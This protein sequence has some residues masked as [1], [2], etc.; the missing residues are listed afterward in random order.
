LAIR[1]EGENNTAATAVVLED[2]DDDKGD[3]FSNLMKTIP[4]ERPE[5]NP[6]TAVTREA[7]LKTRVE[8]ELEDY[9]HYC[10]RADWNEVI[11]NYPSKMYTKEKNN[12][13]IYSNRI[14]VNPF[15]TTSLFDI[16]MWLKQVAKE[17]WPHIMV[18]A[19]IVLPKPFHNG[20]QERVFSA[21]TYRDDKLKKRLKDEHFEMKVLDS[22]N[23]AKCEKLLQDI[24][25]QGRNDDDAKYVRN[26]FSAGA[27]AVVVPPLHQP[28]QEEQEDDSVSEVDDDF[29]DCSSSSDEDE[30]VVEDDDDDDDVEVEQVADNAPAPAVG[31]SDVTTIVQL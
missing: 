22:L 11:R 7:S 3:Y 20:F 18:A 5:D 23:A 25:L 26:F 30:D 13:T 17:R 10:N 12:K 15:H 28:S 31:L 14:G 27:A 19:S 16:M 8:S 1:S 4:V 21:G 2:D 6:E 29:V 24:N 9:M